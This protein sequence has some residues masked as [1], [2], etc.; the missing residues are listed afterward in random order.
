MGTPGKP[1]DRMADWMN[2]PLLFFEG[3]GHAPERAGLA[4]PSICPYSA[5]ETAD[6]A[7]VLIAIQNEREWAQFCAR[8]FGEPGPSPRAGFRS[9]MERA[10]NRATVDAH[11]AGSFRRRTRS[12]CADDL[13]AA[14]TAFGFV[15]NVSALTRRPARRR[16]T[17]ET[18]E[19]PGAHRRAR[20][21]VQRCGTALRAGAGARPGY[22]AR[23]G[24]VRGV[25][26]VG[27]RSG[28]SLGAETAASHTFA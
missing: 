19:G 2:V 20:A 27:R 21:A 8:F 22:R 7:L 23:P 28:S 15:N 1:L 5:F 3:T 6:G 14:G 12:A 9:H 25:S 26:Q 10:E 13:R 18:P 17:L 4:H 11:I 16:I 24:G